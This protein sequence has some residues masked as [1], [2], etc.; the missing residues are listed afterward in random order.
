M[1][2]KKATAKQHIGVRIVCNQLVSKLKHLSHSNVPLLQ[3]LRVAV[4]TTSITSSQLQCC[5]SSSSDS[6]LDFHR[7]NRYYFTDPLITAPRHGHA[8][9]PCFKTCRRD[10]GRLQRTLKQL[11]VV[12]FLLAVLLQCFIVMFYRDLQ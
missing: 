2:Q 5:S 9:C 10:K 6:F 4:I 1:E 8:H 11:T 12:S 7:L 3:R